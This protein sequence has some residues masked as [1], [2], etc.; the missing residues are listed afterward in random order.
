MTITQE[1]AQPAIDHMNEDH[2]DANV[3]YVRVW[4]G[5]DNAVEATLKTI[6]NEHMTFDVLDAV[7]K[8]YSDVKVVFEKPLADIGEAHKTLVVMAKD[9][10]K[11]LEK[12]TDLLDEVPALVDKLIKSTPILHLSTAAPDGQSQVGYTQFV[13]NQNKI[14][15][16][17]SEMTVHVQHILAGNPK[18]SLMFNQ[19]IKEAE[20][21][22]ALERFIVNGVFKEIPFEDELFEKTLEKLVARCGDVYKRMSKMADFHMFEIT[23]GEGRYVKGF[24]LIFDRVDG[25]W[26]RARGSGHQK[27]K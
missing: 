13:G 17:M 24:G 20:N 8:E 2:G 19:N 23:L 6:T 25:T 5:I 27:R 10:K 11:E 26:G 4:G 1:Q 3:I 14:Y 15:V 7:G 18:C 12:K 9:G 22:A 16:L 21:L